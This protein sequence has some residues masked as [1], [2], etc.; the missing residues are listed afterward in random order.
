MCYNGQVICLQE[1]NITGIQNYMCYDYTDQQVDPF[2]KS[3]EIN[4][5]AQ[6]NV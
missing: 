6:N 3:T 5:K 2:F 4:L 1:Q